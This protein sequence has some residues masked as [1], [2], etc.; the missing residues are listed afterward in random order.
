MYLGPAVPHR[1]EE[2]G[3]VDGS[4]IDGPAGG[5]VVAGGQKTHCLRDP[6]KHSLLHLG[7]Q[8]RGR[9]P[10]GGHETKGQGSL[11]HVDQTIYEG[12]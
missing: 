12:A 11:W 1:S 6:R 9:G 4:L 2:L 10:R 3:K 5:Q 8:L 7:P